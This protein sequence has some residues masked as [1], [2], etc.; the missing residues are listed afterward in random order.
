MLHSSFLTLYKMAFTGYVSIFVLLALIP[1]TLCDHY[2]NVVGVTGPAESWRSAERRCGQHNERLAIF[3]NEEGLFDVQLRLTNFTDRNLA[4]FWIGGR[5]IKSQWVWSHDQRPQIGRMT[6]CMEGNLS[7]SVY[8]VLDSNYPELCSAFCKVALKR[9]FAALQDRKCYCLYDTTGLQEAEIH[10]CSTHCPGSPDQLCGGPESYT[11]YSTW[12]SVEWGLQEPSAQKYGKDCAVLYKIGKEIVWSTDYC[13]KKHQFICYVQE[14][15][16]CDWLRQPTPCLYSDSEQRDWYSAN[17]KCNQ[18][19]G[20]LVDRDAILHH[21]LNLSNVYYWTGLTRTRQ[22]WTDGSTI[23]S[24]LRRH[25]P[26]LS[27]KKTLCIALEY[28]KSD[29]WGLASTNCHRRH[30]ALCQSEMD[31]VAVEDIHAMQPQNGPHFNGSYTTHAHTTKQT[32]LP[33]DSE[34]H[35]TEANL[36]YWIAVP[37]VTVAL[38]SLVIVLIGVYV[39]KTKQTKETDEKV[40]EPFY[41]ILEKQKQ[42]PQSGIYNNIFLDN[43]YILNYNHLYFNGTLKQMVYD[44]TNVATTEENGV[45]Q[46]YYDTMNCKLHQYDKITHGGVKVYCVQGLYE[47]VM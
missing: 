40:A 1:H 16:V 43:Q 46:N 39:K 10:D 7:L 18:L 36:V 2:Q 12:D 31:Y 30:P 6:G 47:T 45:H 29:G 23:S 27:M 8:R 11:V 19:H 41:Y 33:S 22:I 5:E 28:R 14:S 35:Y 44:S 20:Y 25:I 4:T 13:R 24:S 21:N 17:Y 15:D 38:V 34:S 3:K 32:P 42:R 9:Q 26:F 37:S